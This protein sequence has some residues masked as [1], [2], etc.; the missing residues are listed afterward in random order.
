MDKCEI[1]CSEDVTDAMRERDD[2]EHDFRLDGWVRSRQNV[3]SV[4]CVLCRMCSLQN[5]FSVDCVLCRMCS[6]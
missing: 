4:D 3:F 6:L 2:L 1:E 5:V